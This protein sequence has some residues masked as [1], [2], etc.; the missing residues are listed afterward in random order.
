MY[1]VVCTFCRSMTR[2]TACLAR[3]ENYTRNAFGGYL[4]IN[5]RVAWHCLGHSDS[6]WRCYNN[7]ECFAWA[8]VHNLVAGVIVL[9]YIAPKL[10]LAISNPINNG[11]KW[12]MVPK[13]TWNKLVQRRRQDFE[14]G[15]FSQKSRIFNSKDLSRNMFSVSGF[16]RSIFP[17]RGRSHPRPPWR[18]PCIP[19]CIYIHASSPWDA[20]M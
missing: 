14:R 16:S 9:W 8:G 19:P 15:A 6:D 20:Y 1:N 11:A 7:Y 18:C 12:L 17:K 13:A 3:I 4:E 2:F 10:S 5:R